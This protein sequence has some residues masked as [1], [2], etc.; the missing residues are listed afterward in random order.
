MCGKFRHICSSGVGT[1]SQQTDR[2]TDKHSF[3]YVWIY[4]GKPKVETSVEVKFSIEE[5]F[6]N[7]IQPLSST[8]VINGKESVSLI[9]Y[10]YLLLI[11]L[12]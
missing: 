9:S 12:A 6:F 1:H 5:K 3:L 10:A 2:W 7:R 8:R 4:G 11:E